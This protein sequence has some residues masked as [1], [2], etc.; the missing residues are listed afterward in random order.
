MSQV[1]VNEVSLV[2]LLLESS[3]GLPELLLFYGVP[4]FSFYRSRGRRGLHES[5]RH[6]E[7]NK[8][9]KMERE[10]ALGLCGP[11]SPIG[12]S[13]RSCRR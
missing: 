2:L 11:S 9:E 10:K 5:E 12:R 8:E 1:F 3:N 6:R 7:R 4:R 13:H